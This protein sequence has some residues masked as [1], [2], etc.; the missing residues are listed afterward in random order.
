MKR[1]GRGERY[2]RERKREKKFKGKERKIREK[3]RK[4]KLKGRGDMMSMEGFLTTPFQSFDYYRYYP[5]KNIF[6]KEEYFFQKDS[7]G[8]F[9]NSKSN[10]RKK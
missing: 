5:I 6:F 3:E 7:N 2:Q 4:K 9:S 8:S 10:E 1:E